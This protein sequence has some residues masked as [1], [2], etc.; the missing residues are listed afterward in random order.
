MR[1]IHDEQVDHD[2]RHH[3]S[4]HYEEDAIPMGGEYEPISYMKHDASRHKEIRRRRKQKRKQAKRIME[5]P[6]AR[7]AAREMMK[8][9]TIRKRVWEEVKEIPAVERAI[10]A[11]KEE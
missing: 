8:D 9:P 2:H 10:E 7:A 5:D 11:E 4:H 3:R 6:E 1:R